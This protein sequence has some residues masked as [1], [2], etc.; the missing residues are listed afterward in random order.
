MKILIVSGF[1]GAGKTTFIKALAKHTGKEFAILENE[2]G[3]AGIDKDRLET[4][5]ASGTVNIWEMTQGCI[6][7]SAK[8]DFALSVLSI[9]NA[10][11]PEYLVIEPTGVG[12]LGNIVENLKQI[13]YDRIT[14]LAPVTVVDI[15]SYRRYLQEYPELYQDQIAEAGTILVS[16]TEQASAEEKQQIFSALRAI[17]PTAE[18]VTDHYSLLPPDQWLHLLEKGRDG[19]LHHSPSS[20]ASAD[21]EQLPDSFTLK[22][23]HMRSPESLFLFLEDL[24]RGHFGNIFRAKGQLPAG[25]TWLQFDVADSRYCVISCEPAADSEVVF[26]GTDIHRQPI[27]RLC[28]TKITAGR[29][30]SQPVF[31]RSVPDL[32]D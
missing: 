29:K 15:H 16:K 8:G 21:S 14:L 11:D 2:Y 23:V 6:C 10:V 18:I 17:N 9:A 19:S 26:I 13:E 24:I 12:K 7:C 25:N 30:Y 28:M 4:E 22:H 3:A 27:R 20:E 32:A 31:R 1:L 5:L